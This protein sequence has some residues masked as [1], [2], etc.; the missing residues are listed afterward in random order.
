MGYEMIKVK[1]SVFMHTQKT[2]GTSITTL[3]RS[4]YGDE[5]VI[6]HGD[7]LGGAP[8]QFYGIGFISGHFG[9]SYAERWMRE[10][11]AFTFLRD[12]VERLLSLYSFCRA[13][14][15]DSYP[16]YAA[17]RNSSLESFL[18]AWR[19]LS[20]VDR[21]VFR[22][23]IQNHQTW[24]LCSGWSENALQLDRISMFDFSEKELVDT[25]VAHLREFDYVGFTETFDADVA[26]IMEALGTPL[27]EPLG[28]INVSKN[29]IHLADL[30]AST[31]ALLEELTELDRE[32]YEKAKS[33][34]LWGSPPAGDQQSG[35]FADG[36][37]VDPG[38][39]PEQPVRI[40]RGSAFR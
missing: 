39:I 31:C 19:Q 4:L 28:K 12:P 20:G 23:S 9:Y 8:D 24:Q 21:L 1:K 2:A 10:R 35:R 22:E 25:A 17:A 5:N 3:A 11:Y 13:Q 6:S 33:E 14:Q 27:T 32:V 26:N 36:A 29:R 15:A 16:I 34:R 38:S 7:Y 30:P 40:A 18:T 37:Q